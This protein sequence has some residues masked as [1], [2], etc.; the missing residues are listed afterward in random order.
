EPVT[1]EDIAVYLSRAEWD[2]IA[3]GQRE[4]YHSVM[5]DNY[6]LLTS[7][8]YP[9]PKPDILYRMERGEEPWVCTPQSS[10]RGDGPNSPSPGHNGDMSWLEEPPSGW[11]PGAGGRRLLEERTQT[12]CLGGRCMQWRLRSRMLLNKFKCFGGR[13][14]LPSEVASRGVGPVESQDRA[15]TVFCP[16]KEREVED[17]QGVTANITQSRRF[18]LHPVMEQ[19]NEKAG[20]QERLCGDPRE[21]FQRSGQKSRC[22]SGEVTFVQGNRELSI[23][24]LNEIIL[25]DHC[26][27]VM[28]DAQ[29]LRCTPHPCPLREHDYC[30]NR[31]IGVAA[32]K[33]HEYC[34]VQRIRYQGRVNK[35]VWLTGKA[36]SVLHRLAKR[37]SPIGRIIRKAKRIMWNYKPCVNKRLEFSQGSSSTGSLSEPAVPPAKAEDDPTEGTCGAF[38]SP[39][40]QE[41]VSPQS[42]SKR[43]SQRETSEALSAPVISFEQVAAPSPLNAAAEVKSEVMHPEASIPHKA[44]RSQLTQSSDAKENFEGHELVNSNHVSLHD[45]YKMVMRTVD[46]MLGSVCQNFELGG[47]SQHKDIWPIIIQIDS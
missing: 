8:G 19:Q 14:D 13:S 40:K 38:C 12:P 30:R 42:Q 23:E 3:A 26:Y 4:L 11:W 36:R 31:K 1:F 9:G 20:P 44:Q 24:E 46:H 2:I 7:L 33:D 45:A 15:Q 27:C 29:L 37:K 17:K 25:K 32:L 34:H 16:G 5:L 41:A 47:Y 21:R 10:V 39:A 43:S 6:K 18:P 35:I 22:T 28:S